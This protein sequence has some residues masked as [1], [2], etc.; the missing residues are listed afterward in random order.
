MAED[1]RVA[2]GPD[3]SHVGHVNAEGKEKNSK[4]HTRDNEMDDPE[5]VG[6]QHHRDSSY[7]PYLPKLEVEDRHAPSYLPPVLEEPNSS[8]SDGISH[9]FNLLDIIQT[10]YGVKK[11]YKNLIID[12][13][14]F[15]ADDDPLP[16]IEDLQ[17]SGEAYPGREL[18]ACGI[19]TN[20]T[21]SCNFEV[22]S[23]TRLISFFYNGWHSELEK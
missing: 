5:T 12:H 15:S 20:G 10:L 9:R 6:S 17:F 23:I 8:F 18:Q 16:A 4:N 14:I 1:M 11:Y 13:D 7:D 19:S 3:D 21:T 22:H 2:V